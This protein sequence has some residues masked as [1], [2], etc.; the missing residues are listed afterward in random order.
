MPRAKQLSNPGRILA[1]HRRAQ[2]ATPEETGSTTL[3]NTGIPFI[4]HVPWG[5][6]LCVFYETK[7][8]LI[9]TNLAYFEE[10]LKNNEFC[11]WLV[12]DPLTQKDAERIIFAMPFPGL[13]SI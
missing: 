6:H 7:E 5:A 2:L 4:A 10:G 13:T 9:D 8:D 3:R 1:P 11:I 12:S